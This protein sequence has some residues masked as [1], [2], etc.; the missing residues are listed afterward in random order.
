MFKR[1]FSQTSLEDIVWKLELWLWITEF[2][3][4]PPILSKGV[5]LE[6]APAG[7]PVVK[8]ITEPLPLLWEQWMAKP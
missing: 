6:T 4:A 3:Q 7:A 5:A 1:V 2:L 8:L